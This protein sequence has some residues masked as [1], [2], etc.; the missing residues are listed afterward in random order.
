MKTQ[1]IFY[2]ILMLAILFGCGESNTDDVPLE[3]DAAFK[4]NLL[5][6][7]QVYS[8]WQ[9]TSINDLSL[10][11][12]LEQLLI[13]D[14][15]TATF[16]E[17]SVI[18]FHQYFTAEDEWNLSIEYGATIH[19]HGF[20]DEPLDPPHDH[21]RDSV[22]VMGNWSGTY[23]I[24]DGI[25]SLVVE[26]K[27]LEI[28]PYHKGTTPEPSAE[29]KEAEQKELLDKFDVYFFTP[30]SQTTMDFQDDTLTL[31][32]PVSSKMPAFYNDDALERPY[33]KIVLTRIVE[34]LVEGI[35]D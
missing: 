35:V 8:I 19:L 11:T 5:T 1:T 21:D 28:T 29:E 4:E 2:T 27:H 9:V 23:S 33:R 14:P 12:F 15:D 20:M 10:S 16:T 26:D 6:P 22:N 3:G 30:I 34:R 7:Q 31:T 25:L 32:A 17:I 13:D 24:K 18:G